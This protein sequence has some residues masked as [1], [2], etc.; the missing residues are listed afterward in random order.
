MKIYIIFLIIIFNINT[1]MSDE[2][3]CVINSYDQ[4]FFSTRDS[5]NLKV[6]KDS[7]C[8]QQIL[9]QFTQK[10]SN[11]LGTLKANYLS[12]IMNERYKNIKIEITPSIILIKN[13]KQVVQNN[14]INN[15]N[16][17]TEVDHQKEHLIFLSKKQ[18]LKLS[19]TKCDNL[20]EFHIK[21]YITNSNKRPQWIKITNKTKAK[22][23]V[24]TQNIRPNQNLTPELF[25]IQ[26]IKTI[27]PEQLVTNT[28]NLIFQKLTRP[29]NE[30]T[31]LLKKNLISKN[32]VRQNYPVSLKLKQ[33][34]L[35]LTG[36]GI[37]L[38][39]G[40]LGDIIKIRNQTTKKIIFGTITN[41]NTVEIK[42]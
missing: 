13:L 19:C 17:L 38:N 15:K 22:A 40:K 30:N 41:F 39:S 33:G 29:I 25:T 28:S 23:F 2:N 26:E 11:S 21:Y 16:I 12:S 14:L 3:K 4:I 9:K 8:N 24:T 6:I 36:T 5:I 42:L 32:I 10:L 7:N 35:N 1:S 37:A 27:H 18:Q 34:N 31:P 20:G